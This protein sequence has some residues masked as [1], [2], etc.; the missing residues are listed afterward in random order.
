MCGTGRV[1][2]PSIDDERVQY[3]MKK[4]T[5]P[6]DSIPV[7]PSMSPKTALLAGLVLGVTVMVGIAGALAWREKEQAY[8]TKI[9]TMALDAGAASDAR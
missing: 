5:T 2:T 4:S 8:E 6:M 1:R 9:S 7:P 3:M